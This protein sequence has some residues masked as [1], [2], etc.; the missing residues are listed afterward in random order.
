MYEFLC[1]IHASNSCQ[2]H[3]KFGFNSLNMN[4]TA[5]LLTIIIDTDCVQTKMS[6]LLDGSFFIA[7]EEGL[8]HQ[9]CR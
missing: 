3:F 6:N 5:N 8:F 7:V 9:N 4:F 1:G 2:T